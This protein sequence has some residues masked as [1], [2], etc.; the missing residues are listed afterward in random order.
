MERKQSKLST[1]SS[2]ASFQSFPHKLIHLH[3]LPPQLG[4]KGRYIEEQK[5]KMTHSLG[6]WQVTRKGLAETLG[7]LREEI[8][9]LP[10]KNLEAG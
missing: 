2:S 5:K 7:H 10:N 8:C 3:F 9:L 4:S 6:V 1:K